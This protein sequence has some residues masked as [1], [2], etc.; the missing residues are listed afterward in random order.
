MKYIVIILILLVAYIAYCDYSCTKENFVNGGD[1]GI[2]YGSSNPNTG[3]SFKNDSPI[4]P[5]NK[6]NS[7]EQFNVNDP[8]NTDNS[9]ATST[10]T[11]KTNS[12]GDTTSTPNAS[13]S[14]DTTSTPNASSSGDTTST[15]N[16]DSSSNTETS[17][18]NPVP[19]LSNYILKSK[20]KDLCPS[21]P[22]MSRYVLKTS[23]PKC[24]EK[25]HALI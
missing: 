13:S 11:D 18:S 6:L 21:Q 16:V 2:Y 7:A 10:S 5:V 24:K 9:A 14:G 17:Q 12:S 8:E 15:P 23:I 22:D 1:G 4:V 3:D 19:D 20:A 25:I